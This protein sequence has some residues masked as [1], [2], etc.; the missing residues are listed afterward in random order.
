[1]QAI[2]PQ[3]QCVYQLS[4]AQPANMTNQMEPTGGMDIG[5]WMEEQN[6]RQEKRKHSESDIFLTWWSHYDIDGLVQERR[7][8]SALAMELRLSCINPLIWSNFFKILTADIIQPTCRGE[9]WN[10]FNFVS[11]KSDI[12]LTVIVAL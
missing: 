11:L 4:G 1:M 6:I 5:G 7:N 10:T 2:L 3:L 12:G 9:I 8:S